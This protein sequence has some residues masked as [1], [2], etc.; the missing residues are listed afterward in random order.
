MIL[1]GTVVKMPHR[2]LTSAS[3]HFFV[4]L[5][6]DD[7]TQE[8]VLMCVITSKIDK[9]KSRIKGIAAP[10]ETCVLVAPSDCAVLNRNCVVDCNEV[11]AVSLKDWNSSRVPMQENNTKKT[12][13]ESSINPLKLK[14]IFTGVLASR[15]VKA[16]YKKR[17]P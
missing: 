5:H 7:T 1:P 17:L 8:A 12:T 2:N 6:V 14:D 13:I 9:V 4:V 3:P 15:K 16:K 10:Q 11:F